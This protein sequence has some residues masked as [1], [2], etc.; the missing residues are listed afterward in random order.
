M[1]YEQEVAARLREI[2][3]KHG[4]PATFAKLIGIRKENLTPYISETP[5]AL[6]GNKFR[7]RMRD[8][9]LEEEEYYVM[10][11]TKEQTD[12]KHSKNTETFFRNEHPEKAKLLDALHDV[13]IETYD[14]LKPWLP[15]MRTA[16]KRK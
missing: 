10:Y 8:A 1:T 11:G 6:P 4:G 5:R 3:G 12:R 2:A 16:R 14:Q 13:G 9:G 15:A 7:Q